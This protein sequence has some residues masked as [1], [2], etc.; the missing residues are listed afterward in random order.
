MCILSPFGE[1]FSY[2]GAGRRRPLRLVG[3]TGARQLDPPDRPRRVE[4]PLEPHERWHLVSDDPDV[5][6]RRHAPEQRGEELEPHPELGLEHIVDRG[7]RELADQHL[8]L[9]CR[10]QLQL[11]EPG[12][13]RE[14]HDVDGLAGPLGQILRDGEDHAVVNVG[15]QFERAVEHLLPPVLAGL[16]FHAVL[17]GSLQRDLSVLGEYGPALHQAVALHGKDALLGEYHRLVE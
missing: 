9:A 13:G 6:V 3:P 16:G 2:G 1:R 14:G 15:G 17:P 7:L 5:V 12:R 10:D 8:V 11:D 4:R